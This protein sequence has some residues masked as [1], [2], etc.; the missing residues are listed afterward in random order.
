[1]I[2]DNFDLNQNG[3]GPVIVFPLHLTLRHLTDELFAAPHLHG[4]E[5]SAAQFQDVAL[6]RDTGGEV[7][8]AELQQ[9]NMISLDIALNI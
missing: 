1:M 9:A 8:I 7:H 4:E 5:C 2:L 3:Q 6:A